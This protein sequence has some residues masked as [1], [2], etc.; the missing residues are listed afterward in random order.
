MKQNLHRCKHI[1]LRS[2]QTNHASELAY[3]MNGNIAIAAK[4]EAL[5]S[6]NLRKNRPLMLLCLA[7]RKNVHHIQLFHSTFYELKKK[8]QSHRKTQREKAK[9]EMRLKRQMNQKS[10]PD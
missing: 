2:L 10:V 4:K 8:T 9:R 7:S 3:N 5:I 6:Q 1:D